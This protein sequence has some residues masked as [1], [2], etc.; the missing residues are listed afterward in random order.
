MS[1]YGILPP[2][3][4][5]YPHENSAIEREGAISMKMIR[6]MAFVLLFT[7]CLA[8]VTSCSGVRTALAGPT[9]LGMTADLD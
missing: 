1:L 8:V 9:T 3:L 6:I 5:R 7:A 4:I 2:E